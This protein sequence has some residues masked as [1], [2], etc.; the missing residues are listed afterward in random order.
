MAADTQVNVYKP[1]AGEPPDRFTVAATALANHAIPSPPAARRA[2]NGIVVQAPSALA[3]LLVRAPDRVNI[4]VNDTGGSV[5]V[6]DISGNA[7]IHTTNGDINVMV[8]GY[9]QAA[10]MKGSLAVTVGATQWPGTLHFFDG[11]GDMEI[12]IAATAKFRVHMHTDDGTL[13]TDFGLRGTSQGTSE[14]IDGIING[15]TTQNVDIEAKR[16]TIR[17]LRLAPQA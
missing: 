14:T 15:G 3:S 4:V 16:G 7:D 8:P 6:T 12:Y 10:T 5:N 13:F 2:G 17:L 11:D 9:A 1:A